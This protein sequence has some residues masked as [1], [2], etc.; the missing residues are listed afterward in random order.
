[1]KRQD[2]QPKKKRSRNI[3]LWTVVGMS[4]GLAIGFTTENLAVGLVA[5]VCLSLLF[6]SGL[7]SRP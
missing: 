6:A 2:G 7:M 1:M 5:G 3:G 4:I